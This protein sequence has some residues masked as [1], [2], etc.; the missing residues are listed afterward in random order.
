MSRSS[1]TIV[2]LGLNN[3]NSSSNNPRNDFNPYTSSA[4]AFSVTQHLLQGLRVA[5]IEERELRLLLESGEFAAQGR[6]RKEFSMFYS[7]VSR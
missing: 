4:L 6:I 2:N 5:G 7:M 3:T 1:S